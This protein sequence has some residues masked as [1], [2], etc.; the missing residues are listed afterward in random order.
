MKKT[1]QVIADILAGE[2]VKHVF[3]VSGGEAAEMIEALRLAGIEYVLVKHEAVAAFIADVYGQITG[4]PGVC[5]S[6]VGPGATNLV[7]GLANAYL[8][9]SPVIAISAT[10]PPGWQATFTH[11]VLDLDTL[12]KPVT[13]WNAEI[14]PDNIID[15]MSR[16][17]QVATA[18]RPGPVHITLPS[19][20]AAMPARLDPDRPWT[21]IT[22]LPPASYTPQQLQPVADMIAG[23]RTPVLLV[24]LSAHRSGGHQEITRLAEQLGAPVIGVPKA[25]G[26]VPEDHPLAV[27]VADMA[28]WKISLKML[29]QADLFIA[30]G[31]DPVE[32][33]APWCLPA[34]LIHIDTVPNHDQVY[35]SNLDVVGD[36]KNIVTALLQIIPEVPRW[37]RK[38]IEDWKAR[39]EAAVCPSQNGLTPWYALETLRRILPAD[40]IITVDVGAHKQLAGQVWQAY[41]P[42]TYFNSNGLSSMGYG[43]PAAIAAKLTRPERDVVCLTGDGGFSMVL[44]DLETA[45][46]LG[47]SFVT[48]V[49]NDDCLSLIRISQERREFPPSGVHS[50]TV[51]FAKVAEGFGATGITVNTR[52]EFAPAIERALAL[53][54]PVVVDVPLDSSLFDAPVE[55]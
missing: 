20:V 31:F 16:A 19:N 49:F 9:R 52:A 22:R 15:V 55:S 24:G 39:I 27:A 48:V 11:Q 14:T 12:F 5:L 54:G 50:R 30:I 23:S 26:T 28:G 25:K 43:F 38:V 34:P 1:A 13:K 46:R 41:Q 8:D 2:G 47:L 35:R 51:D 37:D 33:C 45:V 42:Y 29:E 53:T 40:G 7:S 3:G 17:L 6:T 18:E 36:I 32:L 10:V 21:P 44:P 4:Q